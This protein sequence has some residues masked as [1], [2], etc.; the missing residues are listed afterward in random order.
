MDFDV[1]GNPLEI[2]HACSIGTM[3]YER[4]IE[5]LRK[6]TTEE[7]VVDEDNDELEKGKGKQFSAV[8][9]SLISLM[10]FKI[11]V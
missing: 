8:S 5:R 10:D 9:L 1:Q 2:F 4:K 7:L 11:Y 6:A 3:M